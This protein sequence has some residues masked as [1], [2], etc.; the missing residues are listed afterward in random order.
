MPRF[1]KPRRN[2]PQG[3]LAPQ[4]I[5]TGVPQAPLAPGMQVQQ[6]FNY[7]QVPSPTA[8]GSPLVSPGVPASQEAS[9]FVGPN[10]GAMGTLVPGMEQQQTQAGGFQAPFNPTNPMPNFAPG[11]LANPFRATPFQTPGL[12]TPAPQRKARPNMFSFRR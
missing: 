4:P 8:E 9:P 12:R 1:Y 5:E 11:A 10:A 7:P 3:M 6:P 2:A